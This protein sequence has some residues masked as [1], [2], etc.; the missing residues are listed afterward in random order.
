MTAMTRDEIDELFAMAEVSADDVR[1]TALRMENNGERGIAALLRHAL[2][3]QSN[4][5]AIIPALFAKDENIPIINII[6]KPDNVFVRAV[7]A[8]GIDDTLYAI[9]VKNHLESMDKRDKKDT[10]ICDMIPNSD[11]VKLVDAT[12]VLA[13]MSALIL[14]EGG[15]DYL[16]PI[17][18]ALKEVIITLCVAKG[19]VK[20]DRPR[21]FSSDLGRLNNLTPIA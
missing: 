6:K 4:G 20:D 2:R 18:S 13:T 21:R 3:E 8:L 11:L 7:R 17:S 16:S 9:D 14:S 15:G 10:K 5:V 1:K 12:G 19:L